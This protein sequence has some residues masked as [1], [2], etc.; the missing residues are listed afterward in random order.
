MTL[1]AALDARRRPILA[2]A[3][4]LSAERLERLASLLAPFAEAGK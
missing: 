3:P 4:P 2:A 1:A